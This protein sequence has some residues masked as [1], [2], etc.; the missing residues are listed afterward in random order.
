MAG[1]ADAAPP[2][3][4]G[5]GAARDAGGPAAG[6]GEPLPAAIE[7]LPAGPLT[8]RLAAPPSK[9]VTNRALVCAALAAGTSQ[10]HSAPSSDDPEAEARAHLSPEAAQRAFQQGRAVSVGAALAL[11][12][13]HDAIAPRAGQDSG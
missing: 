10:L 11:A 1:G 2:A 12:M 7:L 9:S 3:T 13:G 6:T 8:A 4:A 5:P